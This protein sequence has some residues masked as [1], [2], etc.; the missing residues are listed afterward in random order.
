[1]PSNH[2]GIIRRQQ[3]QGTFNGVPGFTPAGILAGR[4]GRC[5]ELQ[6]EFNVGVPDVAD[7]LIRIRPSFAAK[8]ADGINQVGPGDGE[9]PVEDR[10]IS[11]PA[12]F[13]DI[14]EGLDVGHL[15]HIFD[16][17]CSQISLSDSRLQGCSEAR[18]RALQKLRK[19]VFIARSES[20]G[21]FILIGWHGV[22]VGHTAILPDRVAIF[23]TLPV[24]PR[25]IWTLQAL[26]ASARSCP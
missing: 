23:S 16:V 17:D 5:A 1:M 26:T 7:P 2:E 19:S 13:A 6:Q 15:E 11:S 9:Q 22:G 3:L 10:A 8:C 20:R 25:G 14:Q 18:M 4:R 21:K 12:K 24:R